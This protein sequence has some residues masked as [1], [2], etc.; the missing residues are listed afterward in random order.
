M[1]IC[2]D[3]GVDGFVQGAEYPCQVGNILSS[4]DFVVVAL[5]CK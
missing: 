4:T 3:W 1:A 2:C 5:F